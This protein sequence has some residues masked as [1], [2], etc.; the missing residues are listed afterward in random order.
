MVPYTLYGLIQVSDTQNRF[1]KEALTP[2]ARGRTWAPAAEVVHT[3]AFN[4][5]VTV[6]KG[7]NNVFQNTFSPG[8]Q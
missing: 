1:E 7:V 6:K 4:L 5:A 2:S 3:N 8:I